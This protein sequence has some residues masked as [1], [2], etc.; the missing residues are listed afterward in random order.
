[1]SM[2]REKGSILIVSLWMASVFAVLTAGLNFQAGEHVSLI[3]REERELEARMDFISGMALANEKISADPEPHEDSRAK[4]WLGTLRLE[5]PWN[6]KMTV[7][8]EDEESKLNLNTASEAFLTHFLKNF[9]EHVSELQGSRK[10]FVRQIL[11]AREKGRIQSLEELYLMEEVE[12]EDVEKLRP[13]LTVYPDHSLVNLNTVDLPVLRALIESLAGDASAK[14]ELVKKIERFR[15]TENGIF[16]R[17]DIAPQEF[18]RRIH[19]LPT[20]QNA[21]LINQFLPCITTDSRT[22]RIRIVSRTGRRAEA[23][24]RDG[25][26][27]G[28]EILSWHEE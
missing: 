5:K 26:L 15:K 10:A 1:M 11:K 23:V 13:Y 25:D 28:L 8:I 19:V 18:M 7:Q 3:K 6:E 14:E 17:E 4:E 2:N 21:V 12:K 20:P 9:V 22:Y 24:A 16:R 27:R